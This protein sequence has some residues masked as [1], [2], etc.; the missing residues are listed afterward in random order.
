MPILLTLVL[1]AFNNKYLLNQLTNGIRIKS[2][3]LI[4]FFLSICFRK[5][6]HAKL[7]FKKIFLATCSE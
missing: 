7:F 6:L 2:L 4:G 3:D 1:P 5:M